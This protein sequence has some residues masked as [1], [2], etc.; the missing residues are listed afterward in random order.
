MSEYYQQT[1]HEV[2]DFIPSRAHN[3]LEIGCGAGVFLAQVQNTG[4]KWG[5]EP[6]HEA[7]HKAKKVT[8]NVLNG[9]FDQVEDQIPD[10]HFDL[11]ICNDVIEHMVNH[12]QFFEQIKKKLAPNGQIAGSIPNV[13]YLPNLIELIFKA[14]WRYR[15]AGILDRTHLRFFTFNS[16]KRTF[17][18]H[19]YRVESLNGINSLMSFTGTPKNLVKVFVL[20]F[21]LIVS[22][23]KLRDTFY[24]QFGFRIQ[25][26]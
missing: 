1:R 19:N 9:T 5:V 18:E 25:K 4:E 3:I 17:N 12:D 7:F 2:M 8:P 10:H 22:F 16:L 11:V 24:M 20:A 23:G 21:L 6:S 14:D 26:I 15:D 13:R